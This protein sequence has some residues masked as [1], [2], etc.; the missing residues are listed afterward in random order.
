MTMAPTRRVTLREA[1]DILGMSKEAVRKRVTRGTL[2]S[3]VAEDG[4]RYVCIDAGVTIRQ[5]MSVM[6]SYLR[7]ALVSSS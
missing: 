5:P 1:A 6:H 7:C 2:P 3:G 4:R